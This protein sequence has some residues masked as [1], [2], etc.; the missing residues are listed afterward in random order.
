MVN[1]I[2]AKRVNH[3][4]TKGDNPAWPKGSK[5]RGFST[6]LTFTFTACS[7]DDD[8]VTEVTYTY[9]FSS[10]S[11]SHPDFLEE[12]RKIENAFQSALGITG[13]LFTK[14]GTIEECDKQ[15]YEACRKAFDSL[16]S[17]AWQGDYTFQV[18]NVGTGKVVCTATFSADNENFI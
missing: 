11:A 13:K 4:V 15:V 3:I 5:S 10:M 6:I 17:E 8:P 14:K 9:G 1:A 7:D 12:M 18:T 2:L 16:K